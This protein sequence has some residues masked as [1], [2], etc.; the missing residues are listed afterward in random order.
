MAKTNCKKIYFRL[1]QDENGYPPTPWESLW[2][3]RIT[4][5]IF[6]IDNIPF[7]VMDI[8]PGDRIRAELVNDR[9]E[10]RDTVLRGGNSVFR[11]YVYDESKIGLSRNRFRSLGI[12]SELNYGKMFAIEIPA[13]ADIGPVLDL[14]MEGQDKGEWDI[15]EASLRHSV[16]D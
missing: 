15:E 4:A 1:Q 5:N 13:K 11:V 12:Q 16:P 9:Y 3:R 8:S 14:L 7:Y 10:Y 2:G 6:E